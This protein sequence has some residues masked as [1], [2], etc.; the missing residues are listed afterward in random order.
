MQNSFV[1]GEWTPSLYS[2]TDLAKYKNSL[3][4]MENFFPTPQG[5]AYNRGGTD[6]ISEIKV[7]SKKVRLIRFQFSV[8]QAYMLEFGDQYIRF[9][10]DRGNI[11][12]TDVTIT[13]A[14]QTNPVDISATAHGYSTGDWVYIN[15][16]VGMTE[17]NGRVYVVGATLTNFFQ[18][19]DSNGD[20]IDGTGYT[21][22]I[23]GG[24]SNKVYT[25]A[26]PYLEA[27]LPLLK[28]T[29][30]ADVLYLTHD[31]YEPRKL[32][33]TGHTSWA[34]TVTSFGSGIAAPT[35]F[36]LSVGTGTTNTYA[37]TAVS[38][39]GEE[40]ILSNTDVGDAGDTFTWDVVTGAEH[41]NIYQ[42]KN[43]V[44]GYLGLAGTNTFLTE[45]DVDPDL[46]DAP[47]KAKTP[48]T[49]AGNY[50][51]VCALYQQR[52]LY[53]G[54]INFPQTV[55]GSRVGSFDN[56]N[57]SSPIKSD[58]SFEFAINSN[59]VNAIRWIA[60]MSNLL[61]GTV[62]S[63]WKMSGGGGAETITPT[64][65]A[66]SRQS[67]WGVS[68]LLPL[69]V[70]N[71][72]LFV[73][74]AGSVVRELAFSF[75]ANSYVGKDL[76]ILASHLF[77]NL[78]L[79]DWAYQRVPN[80]IIWAVR[81]DGKLL[82]FTYYKEHEVAGWHRHNTQ[83]EF[84]N[85]ANIVD[86]NGKDET[87]V[88]VK[89]TINGIVK[90]YIEILADRLPRNENYHLN[91]SRIDVEDSYF[92]DSGLSYNSPAT[93]TGV[94]VT[95][96]LQITVPAHGWT[97]ADEGNFFDISGVAGM[98]EINKR[99]KVEIVD[100]D[101]IKLLDAETDAPIDG[102]S[103]NVY[104]SG[105]EIR[106]A[107]TTITGLHHLEGE[108]LAILANGSVVVGKV[109]VDGAITFNVAVSRVH[110][111][112][113]YTSNLETLDFD[114]T[115]QDGTV[116]DKLRDV[117]SVVLE[118]ENTRALWIGPDKDHLLEVPFRTDEKYG[119][120]IELF[121]GEKEILVEAGSGRES[122]SYIRNTLPLP[123]GVL[124]IIARLEAG[125][126]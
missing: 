38:E 6:F 30:S 4:L 109:V 22:Y 116:Q 83:G 92:V 24:V 119:T 17:L 45:A 95:N 66:V 88:V 64:S 69:I 120:P 47:P 32:S 58:D 53:G 94:P 59:Q 7:S 27:D 84:E 11:V 40:S 75:E 14:S 61:I 107:V 39:T 35:N 118:L 9:Y 93:I 57:F 123:T 113:G 16:V 36:T 110:M 1:G 101:T 98:T 49:G 18:L 76:S 121:N 65:V 86:A 41:Y 62:G 15:D 10:K 106:K 87:Y 102:S 19:K 68:N 81:S 90:R 54:S 23:S 112:L 50:P 91:D 99:F 46:T 56:M 82:G 8:E 26:S 78:E 79:V 100:V 12:E 5:G 25:I 44:F 3:R 77:Q 20:N 21:A 125:E 115:G 63:E 126:F 89:R 85:V 104:E 34:L 67:Q 114:F 73:E 72:A 70:G 108:T 52:M 80:S 33:R 51:G 122:R 29:Q 97:V 124:S 43:G 48:F 111:G 2:R 105:G 103:Y 71:A 13:G 117:E 42:E 31:L 96:P 74:N 60:V 55:F 28:F 37:V